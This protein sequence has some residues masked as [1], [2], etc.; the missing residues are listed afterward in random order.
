MHA[1]CQTMV[2]YNHYSHACMTY[3]TENTLYMY[4]DIACMATISFVF[5]LDAIAYET[6]DNHL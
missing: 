6:P 5:D 2:V 4:C 3:E 1:A